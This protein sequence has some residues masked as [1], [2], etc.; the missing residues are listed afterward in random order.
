[1]ASTTYFRPR[2]NRTDC[3]IAEKDS[4]SRGS[5]IYV[6]IGAWMYRKRKLLVRS[7]TLEMAWND[8]LPKPH[9]KDSDLQSHQVQI[10][11]CIM[12][13]D[14]STYWIICTLYIICRKPTFIAIWF[15]LYCPLQSR[16]LVWSRWGSVSAWKPIFEAIVRSHRVYPSLPSVSSMIHIYQW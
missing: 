13:V 2:N 3:Q 9:Q 4:K 15:S 7:W 10:C 1:M 6:G 11:T 5:P 16:W 12:C 8:Q 14:V